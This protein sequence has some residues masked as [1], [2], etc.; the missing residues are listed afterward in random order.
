[1][2]VLTLYTTLELI[3]VKVRTLLHDCIDG[4]PALPLKAALEERGIFRH[5]A[6]LHM[7][8]NYHTPKFSTLSVPLPGDSIVHYRP[9]L[10]IYMYANDFSLLQS[11]VCGL[12]TINIYRSNGLIFHNQQTCNS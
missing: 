9:R 5:G 12:H 6:F 10:C 1:M 3:H 11:D 4:L 2:A 7:G 8:C